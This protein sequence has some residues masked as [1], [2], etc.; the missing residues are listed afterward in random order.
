MKLARLPIRSRALVIAGLCVAVMAIAAW[1]LVRR[2]QQAESGSAAIE[3]TVYET[4]ADR[5]RVALEGG[6]ALALERETRVEVVESEARS[7]R[8]SLRSGRVTCDLADGDGRSFVL[9]AA[10]LELHARGSRFTVALSDV[11][12][13]QRVDVSVERGDVDVKGTRSGPARLSAGQSLHEGPPAP[14]GLV[15]PPLPPP[16]TWPSA[17][18]VPLPASAKPAGNAAELIE[19]ANW[20]RRMGQNHEAASAYEELLERFPNDRTAG[21]AAFELGRLRMDSLK[22][23]P[24][25]TVA[26]ERVAMTSAATPFREE[27]LARLTQ[28]YSELGQLAECG[29]AKTRYLKSYPDGAHEAAVSK[30]C[31]VP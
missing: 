21:L 19:R 25:A 18:S 29:R 31:N 28:A 5:S 13:G 8:L 27:A 17:S 2:G 30:R 26:F 14:S 11:Q 1:L 15:P 6:S 3:Q 7:L 12:N 10:G 9:V 16:R 24:G 23:L 20:A 4:H 22:D